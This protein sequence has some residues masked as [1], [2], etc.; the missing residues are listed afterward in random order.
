MEP[1]FQ[2]CEEALSVGLS[3]EETPLASRKLAEGASRLGWKAM[4]VPRW[5][6][7]E[8]GVAVRQSMTRTMIPRAVAAGCKLIAGARAERLRRENG[9]WT[10]TAGGANY[11]AETVFLATGAVQTPHLLRRSGIGGGAWGNIG[12]TLAMHPTVKI[13]A[14][15]DDEVNHENLGVPVHQVKEFSPRMSLDRKST[16]L[17]SSHLGIS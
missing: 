2:F 1:H 12:N 17:N 7:Y 9:R 8:E 3:R 15:F 6:R 13:V 14:R 16:R 4:E 10:V 5:Y 11:S